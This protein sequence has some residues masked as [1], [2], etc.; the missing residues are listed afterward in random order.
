MYDFWDFRRRIYTEIMY[1]MYFKN[2]ISQICN[3]PVSQGRSDVAL[4]F[5]NIL[6]TAAPVSYKK[7][8]CKGLTHFFLFS[9]QFLTKDNVYLF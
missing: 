8:M 5:L 9:Y 6:A 3:R 4:R 1:F 2:G 7:E